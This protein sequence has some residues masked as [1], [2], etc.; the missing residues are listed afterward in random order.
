MLGAAE[1]SLELKLNR[2]KLLLQEELA[3]RVK[4]LKK[5][6]Q[7]EKVKTLSL[8]R[9]RYNRQIL[10][11]K[12]KIID[13]L[14]QEA[15]GGIL[16]LTRQ[17][18]PAMLEEWLDRLGI[19]EKAELKLSSKDLKGVGPELVRKANDARGKNLFSL[20]ASAVDIEGGF[21]LKAKNF[22]IDRSLDCILGHLR[23]DLTSE[24]AEKL[25]GK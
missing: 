15:T 16:T 14:F 11:L 4:T 10:E 1:H 25:F 23:E 17:E 3:G 21:I 2:E 12:N 20:A 5:E 24:V 18:Y 7:E 6:L 19:D 8:L 22:E 9:T 13:R